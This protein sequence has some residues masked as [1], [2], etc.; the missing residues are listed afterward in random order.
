[1]R[2]VHVLILALLL[3]IPAYGEYLGD[4]AIDDSVTLRAAINDNGTGAD[5]VQADTVMAIVFW[6]TTAVETIIG[7]LDQW[8][9]NKPG[10]S[11]FHTT[12][13]ADTAG[14]GFGSWYSLLYAVNVDIGSRDPVGINSWTV[15][16]R[17]VI[18]TIATASYL[19]QYAPQ[20]SITV[21]GRFVG[22]DSVYGY[23]YWR[24]AAQDTFKLTAGGFGY[25]NTL[26]IDTAGAGLG[27]WRVDLKPYGGQERW[28]T[29]TFHVFDVHNYAQEIADSADVD[30][31]DPADA[32]LAVVIR[33]SFN[34]HT[35]AAEINDSISIDADTV[36]IHLAQWADLANATS[37]S[38]WTGASFNRTLEVAEYAEIADSCAADFSAIDTVT[39]SNLEDIA[40]A[41]EDSLL[42]H[43]ASFKATTTD[44]GNIAVI[45]EAVE[46]SM[47]AH[48]ASFK[49]TAAP[50][51][52][53]VASAVRDTQAAYAST[54]KATTT[55]I[56]N[57]A[58]MAEA[59]E[60]SL[61]AHAASFKATALSAAGATA[62]ADET[63]DSL[64][65]YASTFKATSITASNVNVIAKAVEDSLTGVASTFKATTT[66]VGNIAV[67]AEAI[68]DS[69][70]AHAASFKQT[71]AP[72]IDQV[73]GAVEDSLTAIASTFKA[74]T[75]TASN[76]AAIAVAAADSVLNEAANLKAT[77]TSVNNIAVVAE[78]IEDSLINHAGS[79]KATS[80]Q[81]NNIEAVA[82]AIE[83]S[84]LNHAG[85]FKATTAQVNNIAAVS[86]AIRD[87]MIAHKG[88]FDTLNTATVLKIV[89]GAEDS[90][91]AHAA[92]FKATSTTV[93]NIAVVAEAIED[94]L[95][96]HAS[97]FKATPL[98]KADVYD[99]VWTGPITGETDTM[100]AGEFFVKLDTV[101]SAVHD[102][103]DRK[104]S[105]T[106]QAGT[107]V[108]VS[109]STMADIA[110][111]LL[112]TVG[113][114]TFTAPTVG[115]HIQH[116]HPDS[117]ANVAS[118]ASATTE[119]LEV[120]ALA[121]TVDSILVNLGRKG[122][123]ASSSGSAIAQVKDVKANLNA[124]TF[125]AADA[126]L[127]ADSI[128][129]ASLD[130]SGVVAYDSGTVGAALWDAE[131]GFYRSRYT[132][133]DS[134]TKD[135][136]E[137]ALGAVAVSGAQVFV[138]T[139]ADSGWSNL[140]K[141]DQSVSTDGRYYI[142]VYYNS[143]DTVLYR[144]RFH[145]PGYI[146]QEKIVRF[147][148]P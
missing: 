8:G 38:V 79:F 27:S 134:S 74:T 129:G 112:F 114:G 132:V 81:V 62:I 14:G 108:D 90:L 76:V 138:Y 124:V 103:L 53:Q 23:R 125:D 98:T 131:V 47:L 9:A 71:A 93:S 77:S 141:S 78:A 95:L 136:T 106:M 3:A 70:L 137:T 133:I 51:I 45:A 5:S 18:D 35:Y 118:V 37:E 120:S 102:S 36:R 41:V 123:A 92:D 1:M 54:Y 31:N 39:V 84:L 127:V 148:Q 19:G 94:S 24:M 13:E 11:L 75:T 122:D 60:D 72:T 140:L 46:D 55:D 139:F 99:T 17:N 32:D 48:A 4:Y 145:A 116:I 16:Q 20:D 146:D 121:D 68:E 42:N 87:T 40:E 67:V 59:I 85:S 142:P 65:V 86:E 105:L 111:S 28:Q 100:A 80:A 64:L 115:W 7:G 15:S 96:N 52:A 128:L 33:D 147:P 83:D 29:N 144:V 91:Q 110:D 58:V 101:M 44:V 43:A 57:I 88:D 135:T 61:L 66:D 82:E 6:Q 73:A 130:T 109:A 89:D 104:T 69:L 119:S 10:A 126:G 2:L 143:P 21:G 12:I 30:I 49:A 34:L 50:T 113:L 25:Y 97:S 22:V 107:A 117:L 26:Y 56:G 63:K